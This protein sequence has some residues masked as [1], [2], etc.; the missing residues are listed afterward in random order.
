MGRAQRRQT[1]GL[2]AGDR[3]METTRKRN[4]VLV[5]AGFAA[6]MLAPPGGALAQKL[7]VLDLA[8][9]GPGCPAQ[10]ISLAADAL[11]DSGRADLR[12]EAIDE[13]DKI[14]ARMVTLGK[15]RV[16]I[17][18]HTDDREA[19]NG[20]QRLS[21]QRAEAVAKHLEENFGIASQVEGRGSS[22]PLANNGT[23]DG[24]QANRRAEITG[25]D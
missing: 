19:P 10:L 17:V 21:E 15:K 18:G 22:E 6:L 4:P 20:A 3:R 14:G 12:P 1:T 5:A 23:A 13:L 24:R 11:F 7:P 9:P 25:I 8:C 16:Y 2:T